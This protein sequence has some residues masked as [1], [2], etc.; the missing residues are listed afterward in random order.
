MDRE[1][2]ASTALAGRPAV[3]LTTLRVVEKSYKQLHHLCLGLNAALILSDIHGG[4]LTLSAVGPY[5]AHFKVLPV[6]CWKGRE[7]KFPDEAV[8]VG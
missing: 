2:E 5:S 8:C 3:L 1:A 7:M 4:S 6:F